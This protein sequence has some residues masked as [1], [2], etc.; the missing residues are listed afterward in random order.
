[1]NLENIIKEG[2][3]IL[4]KNNIHSHKLDAEIIIS[5][6]MKIKK[7]SLVTENKIDISKKN[8]RSVVLKTALLF[9]RKTEP[10]WIFFLEYL[11]KCSEHNGY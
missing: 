3:R 10:N 5:N 2:S 8:W 11:G 4:K 1:M 9:Y 7:E 6:L